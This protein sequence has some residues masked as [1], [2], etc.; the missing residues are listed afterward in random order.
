MSKRSY[1]TVV[2][3]KAVIM[4]SEGM[5]RREI[6]DEL[7]ISEGALRSWEKDN[8]LFNKE[9]NQRIEEI[10]SIDA[11]FRKERNQA[12]L[13]SLYKEFV[14]RNVNDGLKNFTNKDLVKSIVILQNELRVD[15]PGQATSRP[16]SR[17]LDDL[18]DR[19]QKSQS[20]KLF[21]ETKKI[22]RSPRIGRI[23]VDAD[24]NKEETA[25]D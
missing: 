14:H 1:L 6:A 20:G 5:S 24:S 17:K 22:I 2:Q 16:E 11:G 18:Q 13:Y 21:K 8:M 19:F 12:M 9:L 7:N 15:T 4:L 3:R 23:A 10:T 25:G